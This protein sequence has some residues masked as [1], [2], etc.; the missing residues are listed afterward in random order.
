MEKREKMAVNH[1]GADLGNNRSTTWQQKDR[2]GSLQQFHKN[3]LKKDSILR[4]R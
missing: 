2:S 3:Q 4:K 1:A